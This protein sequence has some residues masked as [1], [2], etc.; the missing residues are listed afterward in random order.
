M[1]YLMFVQYSA[2]NLQF[3]LWLLD[4]EKRW[5]ALA[6]NRQD[7]S[8]AWEP[9]ICPSADRCTLPAL[10][11]VVIESSW[12]SPLSSDFDSTSGKS[13]QFLRSPS[14]VFLA[15]TRD[16]EHNPFNTPASSQSSLKVNG[17]IVSVDT[18][19]WPALGG[20]RIP[21]EAALNTRKLIITLNIFR[22]S[23]LTVLLA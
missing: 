12:S 13:D 14:K 23:K 9:A 2:E 21:I 7:L 10:K 5:S 4:Y 1:N 20:A 3:Y 11:S 16:K 8:P 22:S 6:K 17:S 19:P 15:S 18:L